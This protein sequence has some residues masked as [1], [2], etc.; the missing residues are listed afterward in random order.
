MKESKF[1]ICL[2]GGIFFL[3]SNLN[4]SQWEGRGMRREVLML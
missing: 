3:Q 4:I 1:K 2:T